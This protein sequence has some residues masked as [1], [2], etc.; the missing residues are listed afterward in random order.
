MTMSSY[1]SSNTFSG[2]FLY[3]GTWFWNT[4]TLW[5]WLTWL[6]LSNKCFDS[7]DVHSTVQNFVKKKNIHPSMAW[8]NESCN[9]A[10]RN[11]VGGVKA[12]VDWLQQNT[13]IGMKYGCC[14]RTFSVR[15][16]VA[17]EVFATVCGSFLRPPF[18]SLPVCSQN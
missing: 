2:S 8:K 12:C 7:P 17:T 6:C 18:K 15:L 14:A 10:H 3:K 16:F 11:H 13:F 5:L 4:K 9:S 1:W